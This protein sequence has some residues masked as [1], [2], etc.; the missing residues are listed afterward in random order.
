VLTLAE[1]RPP[2]AGTVVVRIDPVYYRPTEVDLLIGNPAKAREKLGW[3]PKVKFDRLARLMV[4]A[5]LEKVC[6]RGF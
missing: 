1:A 4:R 3:E 6:Q 5:D 2:E